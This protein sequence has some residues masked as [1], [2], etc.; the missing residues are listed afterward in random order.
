[1]ASTLPLDTRADAQISS[2]VTT[3]INLIGKID[4][5]TAYLCDL[6]DNCFPIPP[7]EIQ[8]LEMQ[9]ASGPG[10]APPAAASPAATTIAARTPKGTSGSKGGSTSG[11]KGGS[12]SAGGP[13]GSGIDWGTVVGR[14]QTIVGG[15]TFLCNWVVDC[16]NL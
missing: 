5:D 6:E 13:S 11:G 3:T 2:G 8:E 15:G 7:K 4:G 9:S 12:N 14:G 16:S 1:M 10:G